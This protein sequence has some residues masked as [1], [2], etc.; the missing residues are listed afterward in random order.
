MISFLRKLSAPV[1]F[2]LVIAVC[3]WW[4]IWGSIQSLTH[5]SWGDTVE[6]QL[7]F[8]G[9]GVVLDYQDH[10][11]IIAQVIPDTP[12]ARAG[13]TAGLIIQ[14]V[15]D[16]AMEG[17]TLTY[18]TD[19]IHGKLGGKVKL[20][21]IDLGNNATNT[22]EFSRESV[23]GIAPKSRVTDLVARR[24][25]LFELF[26][27]A[28]LF[29][30]AFIRGWP[31][32]AWGFRPTWKLTGAGVLL[33]LVTFLIVA[34]VT[35]LANIMLPVP[36]HRHLSGQMSWGFF[37]L[38]VTLNPVFEEIVE[39]GYFINA[40]QRHGM[41][42]AVIASAAFRA[43]LHLYQGVNA[44]VI[45]FPIGLIFGFVY[46]KWRRLWPLFIAHVIFDFMALCPGL[47]KD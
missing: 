43:F 38:I 21:L 10:H 5:H 32:A 39:T 22:V 41:W 6:P 34:A 9:V 45:V 1:E 12:A 17:K 30:I 33:A 13:L 25:S 16:V 40:L 47:H 18:C 19:L 24:M 11:V 27:L 29:G 23:Q 42:L 26:G 20:E 15:N 46:W 31:L 14:K 35:A 3:F 28:G 2:C 8:V 37:L 7:R 44:V 4:G 36:M